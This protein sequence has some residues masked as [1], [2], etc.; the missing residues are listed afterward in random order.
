MNISQQVVE[1]ESIEG[2]VR[3]VL[4]RLPRH[5]SC[6]GIIN[7][8]NIF[9]MLMEEDV[10]IDDVFD[11]FLWIKQKEDIDTDITRAMKKALPS[12]IQRKESGEYQLQSEEIWQYSNNGEKPTKQEEMNQ[13]IENDIK[14]DMI[15]GTLENAMNLLYACSSD[16]WMVDLLYT[17]GTK[18]TLYPVIRDLFNNVDYQRLAKQYVDVITSTWTNIKQLYEAYRAVIKEHDTARLREESEP[19]FRRIDE[20]LDGKDEETETQI[21]QLE[22]ELGMK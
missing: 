12:V 4:L 1:T 19:F 11:Y 3:D 21:S 14:Q 9:S 5:I 13:Q 16:P 6:H 22:R 8:E 2:E 17:Y 15:T 10:F 20:I 18:T 7:Q